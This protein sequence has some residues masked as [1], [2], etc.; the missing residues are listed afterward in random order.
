MFKILFFVCFL[1]TA[2]ACSSRPYPKKPLPPDQEYYLDA[3]TTTTT[4][5]AMTAKPAINVRTNPCK[6]EYTQWY[7]MNE[8][9]CFT[10]VVNGTLTFN[11]ECATGYEGQRC[12]YKSLDGT[13][14]SRLRKEFLNLTNYWK[15]TIG[16]VGLLVLAISVTLFIVFKSRRTFGTNPTRF[17]PE[18]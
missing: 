9:K 7:C 13:Y 14:A 5:T 16:V 2:D 11:C 17:P 8:G 3:I 6:P 12:E 1:T 4:T 18:L 15:R 10:I